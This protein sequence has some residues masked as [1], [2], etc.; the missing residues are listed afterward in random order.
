MIQQASTDK[1][2]D[3]VLMDWQMPKMDGMQA[4]RKLMDILVP[5]Q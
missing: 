1:P 5:L 3:L 2:F 4:A